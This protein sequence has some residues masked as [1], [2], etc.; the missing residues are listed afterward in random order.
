MKLKRLPS[1]PT[2]LPKWNRTI[3][4]IVRV[5]IFRRQ[6]E[7]RQG[8]EFEARLVQAGASLGGIEVAVLN[9]TNLLAEKHL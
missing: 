1:L 3:L 7:V 2:R 6:S 8:L 4:L 9:Y 5:R